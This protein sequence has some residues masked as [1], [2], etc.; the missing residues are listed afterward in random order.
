MLFILN[1]S[2]YVCDIRALLRIVKPRDDFIMLSDG[3]IAGLLNSP[4]ECALRASSMMIYALENDIVARGLSD[5][6]S[7][8]IIIVSYKQFVKLTEK[9]SSQMRW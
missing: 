2:P 9:H 6:L 7:D 4:A 1:R 5:Y 3:V 8:N